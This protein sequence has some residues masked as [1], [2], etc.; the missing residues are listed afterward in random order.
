MVLFAF[1]PS[2]G[3]AASLPKL[4]TAISVSGGITSKSTFAIQAYVT[5]PQSCYAA[6]VAQILET[7]TFH[8][9]FLVLQV[10]PSS[11]CSGPLYKCTVASANYKL[12]VQQPVEVDTKGKV[13][14]IHLSS[15][16]P[17]P[18]EPMCRKGA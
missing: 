4:A 5:L 1:A 11:M 6:G 16:P 9:H 12:P 13:W 2:I 14:K 17:Q 18:I 7:P 8:R 15:H 3:L 10:P